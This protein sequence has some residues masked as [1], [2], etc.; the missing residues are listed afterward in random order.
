MTLQEFWDIYKLV[1]AASLI[2]LLPYI[3]TQ[4]TELKPRL[5]FL[6]VYFV[7]FVELYLIW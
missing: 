1:I 5:I 2:L 4:I 3:F 7:V 6:G